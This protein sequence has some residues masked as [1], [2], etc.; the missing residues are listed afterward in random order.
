[1]YTDSVLSLSVPLC[2]ILLVIITRRIVFSLFIG[3][4]LSGIM[5]GFA[6]S[7]LYGIQIDW[8]QNLI[9]T[10]FYIYH[11]ISTVFYNVTN[12]GIEVEQSN[13]YVFGFLFIL[14]ILTQ[15]ISYSGGVSAFVKWARDKV[16][17]AKGSEFLAF[18][19]GIVIFIDDYFNALTVGQISKSLNDANH[20]TR[21][22]LA[23]IID[24]TAA[25]VCI[26]MPISSWGAYILGLMQGIDEENKF[27]TLFSSIWGN[28]YAWLTLLAVLLTIFWQINL[29]AMKRNQNIGVRDFLQSQQKT[30]SHI[31]LLIVPIL[32]LILF[33]GILIFYTGYCETKNFNLIE[34][35][36][37]TQTGF[38][39]FWGGF[40][41]LAVS[42]LISY[43]H[44]TSN[45]FVS[46]VKIGILS[47][48]PATLILTLAWS[49]GPIIKNDLQSGIYLANIS[50]VW[51]ET[52]IISPHIAVPLVA[53]VISA[54]IAFCTGTSWGTFAIMLPIGATLAGAHELD[55]SFIMAAILSG[56]VYG[57]H[58][59]PISDTTILSA[60]GAGCSV[61]SHFITQLPYASTVAFV[62]LIS[63]FI[64][65]IT[66][67]LVSGYAIGII[68]CIGIF[69]FYKNKYS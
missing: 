28:Y 43:R 26:L 39:L 15:V 68:L 63:F 65:S 45:S 36:A 57:D 25:P 52:S 7:I 47:M 29:P 3:I 22:R 62:S 32:S 5:V 35:L 55:F 9:Y 49:I 50:K 44:L 19:A 64:A 21:E 56:A 12:D 34:M 58:S 17:T 16:K 31:A 4:C 67:S 38:S 10:L 27:I 20:S 14:G 23:Y 46:I 41:A 69:W 30:P 60:A 13:L 24:S 66:N 11:S 37:N 2:V 8:E 54:F 53:F 18:I 59:S 48:L 42:F 61:Q 1:M 40:C 33:V 6:G 51:L